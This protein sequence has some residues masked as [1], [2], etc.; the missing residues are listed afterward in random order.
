MSSEPNYCTWTRIAEHKFKKECSDIVAV[1]FINPPS[2]YTCTC[3]K[4]ARAS[5]LMDELIYKNDR[6]PRAFARG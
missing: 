5:R 2:Y 1:L 3:G 6:N 4:I